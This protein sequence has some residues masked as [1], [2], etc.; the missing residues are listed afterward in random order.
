MYR[1]QSFGTKS[2]WGDLNSENNANFQTNFQTA[3]FWIQV[4]SVKLL[5]AFS[6]FFMSSNLRSS[7]TFVI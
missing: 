1:Y 3:M 4:F 5:N 6:H 7:T 2:V